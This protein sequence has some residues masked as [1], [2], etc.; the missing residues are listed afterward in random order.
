MG[1]IPNYYRPP[2]FLPLYWR[3][4]LSGTLPRAVDSYLKNRISGESILDSDVTILREYIVHY[5]NAPCWDGN[6]FKSEL[7]ELRSAAMELDSATEIGAWIEKAMKIGLD[8]L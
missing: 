6:G 8:P 2:L 7:R 3:D 4:E 1:S 5:I